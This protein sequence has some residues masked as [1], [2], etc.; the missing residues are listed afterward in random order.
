MRFFFTHYLMLLLL[1]FLSSCTSYYYS[2]LSSTQDVSDKV[3]DRDGYF[4]FENDSVCISY[5][6]QGENAPIAIRVYNKASQPI[7]VDWNQSALIIDGEAVSYASGE[8]GDISVSYAQDASGRYRKYRDALNNKLAF[9]PPHS[10]IE[11]RPFFLE[12]FEFPSIPNK[13]YKKVKIEYSKDKTF[14]ARVIDYNEKNSPLFFASYL[15]ILSADGEGK[16]I[17]PQ[18]YEQQ[19][20]ISRLV[21]TGLTPQKYPHTKLNRGDVFFVSDYK[22]YRTSIIL[23]TA[24][25]IGAGVAIAVSVDSNPYSFDF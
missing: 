11:E 8:I 10:Y 5:N 19:F 15:T 24:I 13:T 4:Y 18:S 23:G 16:P 3:K 21:K 17:N 1:F 9:I 25:A 20:Y 6:F 14:S 2:T 22:N 7:F 12:N